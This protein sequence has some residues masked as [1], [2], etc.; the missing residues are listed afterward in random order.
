ML[1]ILCPGQGGQHA[2]MFDLVAQHPAGRHALEEASA[3]AGF[4][5][6][7]AARGAPDIFRNTL[8]QPLICASELAAWHVLRDQLPAPTL[9]AGYSVGEL[10]AHGCAGTLSLAETVRLATQRA[11]LMD[12]ATIT[13]AGLLALRGLTLDR[14]Q[15]LCAECGAEIAIVNGADQC[16]AGGAAAALDQLEIRTTAAGAGTQRL[17]VNVAAHTSLLAS[18]TSSFRVALQNASIGSPVTPVLAGITGALVHDRESAIE[19][20]AAQISRT[21]QW[22][23]C[24]DAAW[25]RGCRVF[26]ELGSGNALARML[27]ERIPDAAARSLADFR[28]I[29]G[30][31]DWVEKYL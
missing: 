26:L 31:V 13:P 19:A 23:A 4:D 12:A 17:G 7:G 8:A 11:A 30:A 20:L 10:A 2:G 25:E 5:L 16:I 29:N 3:A 21:I 6:A 27:H 28:S 1:A 9:F 24:M 15:A 14:A 18:A 22:A